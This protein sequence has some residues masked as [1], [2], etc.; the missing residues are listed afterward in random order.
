MRRLV[1]QFVVILLA[2]APALSAC[3]QEEGPPV[4]PPSSE[5]PALV[6]AKQ[7]LA[8]M[9]RAYQA[10]PVYSD[11]VTINNSFGG[12]ARRPIESRILLGPGTDAR[13]DTN[14]NELI[15]VDGKMTVTYPSRKDRYI[16]VPLDGDL[17]RTAE[18]VFGRYGGPMGP[19][20]FRYGRPVDE[21]IAV[22]ACSPMKNSS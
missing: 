19:A 17:L 13:I 14:G 7:L 9:V 3:A 8:E 2:G 18:Q 5:L 20:A 4:P 21:L 1:S 22:L 6:Q 12:S 15:A 11:R 10:A 16:E